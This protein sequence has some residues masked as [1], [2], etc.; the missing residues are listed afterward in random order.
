GQAR[1][2]LRRLGMADRLPR[3]HRDLM[4]GGAGRSLM[5]MFIARIRIL[6]APIAV[7]MVA[8]R[9]TPARSQQY[10]PTEQSYKEEQLLRELNAGRGRGSIPDVRSY[11][12]EQ[13]R[14]RDWRQFHEVTLKWIGA[15]AILG[16]LGLLVLFFLIR[17]MVR[18]EGGRSGRTLVRFNSFD[19][20]VHWMTASSFVIL[21]L[22]WLNI[23][24]GKDLLLPYI[25]LEAFT[26][27]SQWA[28]YAHISLNFPFT[29]GVVLIFLMWIAWNIPNRGDA[30]WLKAG[31]GI[32]GHGHPPA[33]RFNAG[34]KMIYW[35]V[36]MGGGLV[37]GSGYFLMFSF[38]W[39]G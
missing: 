22:T 20:L 16:M 11:T 5:T 17:G 30:E 25:G 38:Y 27:W 9:A 34:Q 8:G 31:G 7:P 26:S 29:L 39:T 33:R 28:K 10:N 19:R 37:A 18:I 1:L 2:R 32:V 36:V 13:P 21:A 3:N 23:S 12:S 35:I 15:I 14:G 4:P 6:G 24:F